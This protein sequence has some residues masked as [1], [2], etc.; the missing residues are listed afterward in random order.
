MCGARLSGRC[1]LGIRT[2]H[3]QRA[4]IAGGPTHDHNP[5]TPQ[6]S[7]WCPDKSIPTEAASLRFCTACGDSSKRAASVI[8]L[9]LPGKAPRTTSSSSSGRAAS[10]RGRSPTPVRGAWRASD[11]QHTAQAQ[12]DVCRHTPSRQTRVS[13]GLSPIADANSAIPVFASDMA[14]CGLPQ[15]LLARATC[16]VADPTMGA[17]ADGANTPDQATSA[18]DPEHRT[19]ASQ[20]SAGQIRSA[21]AHARGTFG[22]A[23]TRDGRWRPHLLD[24]VWTTCGFALAR[25]YTSS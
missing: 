10:A 15:A 14:R 19:Q 24:L 16:R 6:A 11:K 20:M 1:P 8:P 25:L 7:G 21:R 22:R 23:G 3:R 18:Q 12:H 9:T 5:L 13:R 2:V 17:E 4:S